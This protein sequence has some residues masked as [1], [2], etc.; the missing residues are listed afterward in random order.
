MSMMVSSALLS[1][2]CLAFWYLLAP[3]SVD[4]RHEIHWIVFSPPRPARPTEKRGACVDVGAFGVGAHAPVQPVDDVLACD[5]LG[6]FSRLER[7][8][9]HDVLPVLDGSG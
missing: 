4:G 7:E 8:V 2:Q 1:A 3:V 6:A 5:V 9:P